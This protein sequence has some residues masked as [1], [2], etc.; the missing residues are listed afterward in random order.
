[1]EHSITDVIATVHSNFSLSKSLGSFSL[2]L[3]QMIAVAD[4]LHTGYNYVASLWSCSI[5][6]ITLL[7]M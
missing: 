7:F 6:T 2:W 3:P 4:V 1:M 5:K